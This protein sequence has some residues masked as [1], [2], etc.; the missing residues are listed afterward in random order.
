MSTNEE[1]LLSNIQHWLHKW[2]RNAVGLRAAHA[3]LRI[4]AVISTIIVAAEL[5]L[6][7]PVFLQILAIVAAATTGLISAFDLG[8]KANRVMNAW[9]ILNAATMEFNASPP[10]Q[11]DRDKLLAAYR[12]GEEIIG[13]VKEQ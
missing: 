5:I 2:H 8:S 6:L 10:G 11:G 7:E 4:L 13:P 3:I 1:E 9:R 12:K